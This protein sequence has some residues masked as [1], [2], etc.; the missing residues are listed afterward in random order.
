M[1]T[2]L[3][4][5]ILILI[6][7]FSFGQKF[8]DFKGDYLGQKPPGNIPEL[9]APGIISSDDQEHAVPA[10]SPDGNEVFWL[11][12]RPPSPANKNW[13]SFGKTMQRIGNRWT[14]PEPTPYKGCVFSHDGKRLYMGSENEGYDPCYVEKC[15]TGWSQPVNLDLVSRY[16]EIK[17][18]YFP[19]FTEEGTIYFMGYAEGGWIN[20][21]IYRA[22]F[23]NGK[24]LKPELLPLNING[25][26]D[27]RNWM[28]YISRDESY[29]IFCSTRGL[30]ESDQGDLFIS[31]RNDEG[32]WTDPVNMGKTIN[33]DQLERF[34]TVSPDGK[35]LF[36]TRDFTNILEDVFWVSTDIIDDMKK[37]V[38]NSDK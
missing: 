12:N 13:L 2:K 32:T 36:F 30:P 20:L 9:F 21:G 11:S 19:T 1:K 35:Y 6:A 34:S 16:P 18:A 28:P 10:F 31:F 26:S 3:L 38:F 22:E 24:Y 29:L 17:Y 5:T 23:I 4:I 15:D 7:G 14:N 25:P 33:T 37:E 8:T 27:V